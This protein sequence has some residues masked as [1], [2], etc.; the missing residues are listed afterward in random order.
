MRA[1]LLLSFLLGTLG[2]LA[3]AP[4]FQWAG[5]VPN[6]STPGQF[7]YV[8]DVDVAPDGTAYVTGQVGGPRAI[9]G[10]TIVGGG[11]VARYDSLGNC[12]WA[13]TSYGTRV[14]VNGAD[15]AY[16]VGSFSGSMAFAGTTLTASGQDAFVAKY[17]AN[18]QE[19]WARQMGGALNDGGYSVA[20]DGL[21]RVHVGGSFRGTGTFGSTTLVA[22]HD[23]TGFHATYDANGT[24]Q[25]AVLAG[26]FE[27][28]TNQLALSNRM[29]CDAA[30]NTY[31]AGQFNGT[32]TF[33]STTISTTDLDRAY[34]ARFD[35]SGNCTWVIPTGAEYGN[36]ITNVRVSPSG[37]VY[38]YGGFAGVSATFGGTVLTNNEPTY[39]DIYLAQFDASGNAQWAEPIASTF[40]N[41]WPASLDVDDSGNAWIS[42]K[43]SLA[44]PGQIGSFPVNTGTFIAEFDGAGT[45]LMA[46]NFVNARSVRH[47][48]G[49]NGDHFLW[50]DFTS[51]E[52]DPGSG[53]NVFASLSDGQEG[54]LA[55]YHADLGFH[56][57]RRLGLHSSAS[58]AAT[59]LAVDPAGNVYS[60][61]YFTAT[62]IFCDDTLRSPL[63]ATHLWLSKRDASG[64]CVWTTPIACSEPTGLNQRST[65]AA[66]VRDPNGDLL[67]TGRFFGTMDFGTVQLTSA[68][69][70]DI[71]LARFDG[72]GN[73]L[74][75]IREG[76][77]GADGAA[78]LARATN[79]DLL[80]TGSFSGSATIAGTAFTSQGNA[81]GFLARYDANGSALWC[82][83]YSGTAWDNGNG[84]SLDIAGNV[85]ITGR[86]TGSA[87]FDGLTVS[88][89]GDAD[90][91]VAKYDPAG[92]L[93]WLTGSTG[94]G[95]KDANAV[96]MGASGQLYITGQYYGTLTV[97]TETVV[98]DPVNPRPF[99]SC[100]NTDGALLWQK[101]FPCSSAGYGA[102]LAA[103]P[104]GDII[105]AGYYSGSLD[106]GTTTVSAGGAVDPYVAAFNSAGDELWVQVMSGTDPVWDVAT[107]NSVIATADHVYVAGFFGDFYFTASEQTGGSMTFDPG[108][109]GSERFAPN[110]GD[111]FVAKYG[112]AEQI[113]P[114]YNPLGCDGTVRIE[115]A[116]SPG[117]DLVIAPNPVD[118][119][120]TL[121]GATPFDARTHMVVHDA[122][123]REM[124]APF[125]LQQG[126]IEV[127]AAALTPG[128]YTLTLY[129][130]SAP[131]TSRF[132][133]Q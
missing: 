92:N 133:K 20:V 82:K 8:N 48:V 26:G 125:T 107:A 105:L 38:L 93:T 57:M 109:P 54:Y 131:I 112:S 123:G 103:R 39:L 106:L 10:D 13:R 124:N 55:R 61:G 52:F 16:V 7:A 101:E 40:F 32:A 80:L 104:G 126:R 5:T 62:A 37:N 46:Q 28:W 98:G 114:P 118:R 78:S 77:S 70:A 132:E 33:G 74:W 96:V 17:D 1:T 128:V 4:S 27:S 95:W 94:S 44:A 45:A 25:W 85:Y 65:S 88:G 67:L 97:C 35:A 30:G 64:N 43:V 69:G 34:L 72:N 42:G 53:T 111:A 63:G 79:G 75:A 119:H 18:G 113:S 2:V 100:F 121:T 41:D 73:C 86:Y 60:T 116:S 21:G 66:L 76:G 102:D 129:I 19:L 56:W 11:Y 9:V 47:A 91:F 31:M 84:V 89:T 87:S 81:D 59:S 58:D 83:A 110:S 49:S 99:L 3:Q 130:A 23:T 122:L 15:G 108:D 115:E 127:D 68:G 36:D 12:L 24:F 29:D 6:V 90:L 71:F 117:A 22:T 50:G 51:A 14:S 120:F